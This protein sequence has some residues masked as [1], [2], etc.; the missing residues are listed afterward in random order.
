MELALGNKMNLCAKRLLYLLAIIVVIPL[1]SAASLDNLIE[2]YDFDFDNGDI[3]VLSFSEYMR[4]LNSDGANDTL[5]VNITANLSSPA[6]YYLLVT[7]D[8]GDGFIENATYSTITPNIPVSAS[9]STAKLSGNKWNYSVQFLDENKSLDFM[10]YKQGTSYYGSYEAGNSLISVSDVK[11]GSRLKIS[12]YLNVSLNETKNVTVFLKYNDSF[13]S[14]TTQ[15]ALTSPTENVDVYFDNETMKATHRVGTFNIDKVDIGDK[16]IDTDQ[17]TSGYD[18]ESFAQTSYIRAYSSQAKDYD[19]D[20]LNDVLEINFTVNIKQTGTYNLSYELYDQYDNYVTSMNTQKTFSTTGNQTFQTLVNGTRIYSK[21][22]DGQYLMSYAK[23][24]I[25]NVTYDFV[26]EPYLTDLLYFSEFERPPQPDLYIDMNVTFHPA[27]GISEV[28]VNVTNFGEAPA[29]NAWIDIFDNSTYEA[30]NFTY[31]LNASDNIKFN[32]EIQNTT[33]ST[34][35]TAIADF[36]N[37]IDESDESNNIASNKDLD[38]CPGYTRT[39]TA[40]TVTI[41][42]SPL[43][44]NADVALNT[45]SCH[46]YTQTIDG[47]KAILGVEI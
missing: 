15:A 35:I 44:E 31:M 4:D 41:T 34:I 16:V 3:N 42:Y 6:L 21:A 46:D 8:Y 47:N 14:S 25:G 30:Q 20:D 26:R 5:F 17:N 1:I 45:L 36:Y 12:L 18:Y 23:L 40:D 19:S 28:V 27:T 32:F 43:S 9:F 13:I 22:L 10:R 33:N 11:E 24:A 7:L 39:I 37:Y 38:N 2:S 29:V